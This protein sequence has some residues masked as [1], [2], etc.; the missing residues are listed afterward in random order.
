M[1]EL[2]SDT[3]DGSSTSRRSH[4]EHSQKMAA[5][6][7]SA[8]DSVLRIRIVLALRGRDHVVHELVSSLGKS[9]PL[10]SQHLRVL[11]RAGIVNSQ[12]SGREVVYRLN[13]EGAADVIDWAADA[14]EAVHEGRV[15]PPTQLHPEPRTE[16][17]EPA[18]IAAAAIAAP[19]EPGI[20][21]GLTPSVPIPPD[22]GQPRT[23]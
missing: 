7:I 8:L 15:E 12:R 23:P 19:E 1:S 17:A 16:T 5:G 22:P 9:Q 14:G 6:I 10:I 4:D 3:T 11:K 20:E 13:C 2:T 18:P 21:P